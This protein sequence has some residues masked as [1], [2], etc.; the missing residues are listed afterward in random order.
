MGSERKRRANMRGVLKDNRSA[1]GLKERDQA[2]KE[3]MQTLLE[4]QKAVLEHAA[5]I[6]KDAGLQLGA[7]TREEVTPKVRDTMTNTMKPLLAGGVAATALASESAKKKIAEGVGKAAEFGKKIKT[8]GTSKATLLA[9]KAGLVE[10]KPAP[11]SPGI[12]RYILIGLGVVALAGLV[13]AVWQTLRADDDLWIEDEPEALD[14]D[15]SIEPE[16]NAPASNI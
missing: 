3:N 11:K 1:V 7:F 13:Y 12:G 8:E 4:E 5:A 10:V 2:S 9:Q 16:S 15:L 6:V 14:E